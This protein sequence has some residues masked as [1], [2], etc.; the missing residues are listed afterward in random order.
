MK[1]YCRY[2][3]FACEGDA[4]YCTEKNKILSESTLR[5]TNHCKSYGDCGM[6]L[7]TGKD[8]DS[9]K[10]TKNKDR[11]KTSVEKIDLWKGTG[12]K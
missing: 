12:R 11:T 2:C 6:D 10:E 8:H 7:I 3:G 1:Q 9:T 4:Y 5:R